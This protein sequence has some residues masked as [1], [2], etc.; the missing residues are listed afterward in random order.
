M[1]AKQPE[2]RT[3][4]KQQPDLLDRII[5][6]T[7]DVGINVTPHGLEYSTFTGLCTLA[8]L[9][10]EAGACPKSMDSSKKVLIAI[11][12]GQTVGLN[13]FQSMQ[14]FYI[15]NGQATL[16]GNAP[17]AIC[18]QNPH[19]NEDG[20][21]EWFE[22]KKERIPGHPDNW[23]DDSITAI[24]QTQRKGAQPKPSYFS[25]ADA[26]KAGLWG[27]TGKLYGAYPFR[28]L[29]FRARG[30]ALNDN[31]GD[32]LKGI[33]IR[34]TF[35]EDV[36]GKPAE[37]NGD[38]LRKEV[39]T[40]KIITRGNLEKTNHPAKQNGIE[41]NAPVIQNAV[42]QSFPEPILDPTDLDIARDLLK[43]VY[44]RIPE[45]KRREFLKEASMDEDKTWIGP[46]HIDGI[47]DV[48]YL[49]LITTRLEEMLIEVKG[50][51]A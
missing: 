8:K 50:A 22:V 42:K 37:S 4:E 16:W 29:K 43:G 25:V 17:L 45:Y 23:D 13:A 3:V 19:W 20:Y 24:C 39:E 15:V 6:E 31:F 40:R 10:F 1:N 11:A 32:S 30:Y 2:T 28:M 44:N 46:E 34:E 26:K 36:D 41:S 27:A 35:D 7:R 21:D 14:A 47:S 12:Q 9:I 33:Q 48:D 5:E 18:R 38:T 49:N 51:K